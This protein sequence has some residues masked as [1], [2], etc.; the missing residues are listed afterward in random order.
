MNFENAFSNSDRD[1]TKSPE[2]PERLTSLNMLEAIPN[3]PM[4]S[5]AQQNENLV[6]DGILPP[7]NLEAET[8]N[9]SKVALRSSELYI[10]QDK[11]EQILEQMRRNGQHQDGMGWIQNFN[12]KQKCY[13]QSR[14]MGLALRQWITQS[15]LG[16][17]LQVQEG[18]INPG[19]GN[20]PQE[21]WSGNGEHNFVVITDR[22]D[23]KK[24]YGDP[25]SGLNFTENPSKSVAGYK[26][27]PIYLYNY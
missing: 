24:Y 1:Q 15:G 14:T 23:G 11:F 13:E 20:N 9:T 18:T 4:N 8:D 22:A 21:F 19:M 27:Q 3:L 6:R 2:F 5:K 16:G 10:V 25:W 12:D 26:G 7:L 17:R